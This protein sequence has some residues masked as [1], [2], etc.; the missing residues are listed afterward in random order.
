[1]AVKS[2]LEIDKVMAWEQANPFANMG[3]G[4]NG[5]EHALTVWDRQIIS[6]YLIRHRNEHGDDA[7]LQLAEYYSL[8]PTIRR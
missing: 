3:P 6:Q 5:K 7:A 1:M 2:A 8:M 4:N